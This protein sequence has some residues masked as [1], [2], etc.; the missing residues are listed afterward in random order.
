MALSNIR[1][2]RNQAAEIS[3]ASNLAQVA[4]KTAISINGVNLSNNEIVLLRKEVDLLCY[5]KENIGGD[6]NITQGF[7]LALQQRPSYFWNLSANEILTDEAIPKLTQAIIANPEAD[8]IITNSKGREGDF[9]ISNVFLNLPEGL[10]L[11]LISGVIYNFP[12][13]EFAFPAAAKFSWTGWGQLGVLQVACSKLGSLEVFELP[14]SNLYQ[15]PFTS[16]ENTGNHLK[17][18]S[19]FE[20]VRS[21]YQHSFFGMPIIVAALF[22]RNSHIRKK[23][24][25]DWVKTNWFKINYFSKGVQLS[26]FS[27][28]PHFDTHWIRRLSLPLLFRV[29]F[30]IS[31]LSF[32]ARYL[33]IEN[34]RNIR[35]FKKLLEKVRR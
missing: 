12:N 5:F 10:A 2:I 19:E 35:Y 34:F 28:E 25:S 29:N 15:K 14:D 9:Q 13:M 20:A 8:I 30:E 23:I 18:L 24:T 1:K 31:I 17:H 33:P 22:S 6:S 7:M 21:N 26:R 11:G 27:S 4:I 16:I 3:E 32:I